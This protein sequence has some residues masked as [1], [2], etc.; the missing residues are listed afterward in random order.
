MI[1][2]RDDSG[3]LL[4]R[5]DPARRRLHIARRGTTTSFD[6]ATFDQATS[7]AQSAPSAVAPPATPASGSTAHHDRRDPTAHH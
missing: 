1:D 6:L 7:I 4:A 2:L 5:Y 3:K